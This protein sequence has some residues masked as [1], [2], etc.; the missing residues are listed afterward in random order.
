LVAFFA[1]AIKI[2]LTDL[3]TTGKQI[4]YKYWKLVKEIGGQIIILVADQYYGLRDFIISDPDG[5]GV[6]FA[7]SSRK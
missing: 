4:G 5:F 1:L 3:L 2:A 7:T 6:R